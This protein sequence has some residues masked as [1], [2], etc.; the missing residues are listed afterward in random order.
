MTAGKVYRELTSVLED[1]LI[2]LHHRAETV[3]DQSSQFG[4]AALRRLVIVQRVSGENKP[5]LLQLQRS[6]FGSRL[7]LFM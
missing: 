7:H 6:A 2:W 3:E 5:A 1:L 4:G